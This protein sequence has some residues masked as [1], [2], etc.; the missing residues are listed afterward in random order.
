MREEVLEAEFTKAIRQLVFNPEFLADVKVALQQSHATETQER[1]E[2]VVRLQAEQTK[3]E[4][5]IEAMYV[6]KLDGVIDGELY[7]RKVDEARAEQA[8]LAAEI[9]RHQQAEQDEQYDVAE[10]AR[11]AADLFKQQPS[12]EKRKLLRFVV[13]QCKWTAGALTYRWRQP[14]EQVAEVE[15]QQ[16]AA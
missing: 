2:A 15:Q 8:R 16:K 5:R 4:R 13:E 12:H 10:L 14:F 3:L 11:R 9:A 6:D 1:E 7:R